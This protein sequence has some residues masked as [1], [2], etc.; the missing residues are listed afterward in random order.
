MLLSGRA[1]ARSFAAELARESGVQ[2]QLR[3]DR[4]GEV[5][6]RQLEG[7]FRLNARRRGLL[8]RTTFAPGAALLI[9]PCSSIHTWGMRFPIDVLFV[10]RSGRIRKIVSRV[11]P[12]RVVFGIGSFAVIELPAGAV[13]ASTTKV[14]D[15]LRISHECPSSQVL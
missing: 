7:A 4:T 2:H 14:G 11:P 15:V 1:V 5:L 8:G 12:W 9:A 13:D 3:N 10:S 6:A